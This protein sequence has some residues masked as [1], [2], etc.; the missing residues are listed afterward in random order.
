MTIQW[1]PGH[2]T[3]A[4]RQLEKQIQQTDLVIE[5]RD[6]RAVVASANPLLDEIIQ[7]KP[8]IIV[9][10]KADLAEEKATKD[11]IKHFKEKNISAISLNITKDDVKGLIN[12]EVK[13]VMQPFFDRLKRRGIRPRASRALIVGIPNVGKST[14][15]NRLAKKKVA[16]TANKPGLTKALKLVKVSPQ[17]E[18]VDSPGML[19]PKFESEELGIHLALIGSINEDLLPYEKLVEESLSKIKDKDLFDFSYED[20]SDLIY[21]FGEKRNYLLDSKVDIER[22]QKAYLRKLRNGEFIRVSWEKVDD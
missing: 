3:K 15:I 9:L 6:A 14:L 8:R 17:L 5:L 7:N 22:S 10:A 1:F 2:M 12:K 13:R 16:S 4:K 21:K 11:W 18:V 20:A 19:W